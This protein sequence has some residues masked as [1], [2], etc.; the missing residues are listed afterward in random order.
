MSL[1]R[2][3]KIAWP[4]GVAVATADK[5]RARQEAPLSLSPSILAFKKT[6]ACGEE[7]P[8]SA[9]NSGCLRRRNFPEPLKEPL[10]VCSA[11]VI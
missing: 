1:I 8:I 10:S 2:R 7:N 9:P 3:N 5:K 11:G 4:I 6:D